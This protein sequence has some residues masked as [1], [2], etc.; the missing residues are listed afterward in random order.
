M[1]TVAPVGVGP[2]VGA[3][4]LPGVGAGVATGVGTGVGP[5]VAVGLGV[6]VGVTA[7]VGGGVAGAGAGPDV[8]PA[9]PYS[10]SVKPK[11]LPVRAGAGARND[12]PY[13]LSISHGCH[14]SSPVAGQPA[15]L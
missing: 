5:G 8:V 4:V 10:Q 6:G 12:V 2:G 7:G 11:F 15:R 9:G 3:G 13:R 1:G 14:S